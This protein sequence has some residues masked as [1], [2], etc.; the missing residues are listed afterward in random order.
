MVALIPKYPLA[1]EG[2]HPETERS[3]RQTDP[4]SK[5][6]LYVKIYGDTD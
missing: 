6:S 3:I 2:I 5:H 4:C 1:P